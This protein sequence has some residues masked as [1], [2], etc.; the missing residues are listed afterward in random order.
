MV[1]TIMIELLQNNVFTRIRIRIKT[2]C[3]FATRWFRTL[4]IVFVL[5]EGPV[6]CTFVSIYNNNNNNDDNE[7]GSS[8][9]Y[10]P[11]P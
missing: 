8:S 7:R 1:A 6:T 9:G 11:E 2:N 10:F 5:A 4:A 3:D